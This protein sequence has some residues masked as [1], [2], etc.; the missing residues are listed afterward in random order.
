MAQ[1]HPN[2][3]DFGPILVHFGPLWPILSWDFGRMTRFK[4]LS[5]TS[6]FKAAVSKSI[7]ILFTPI[8]VVNSLRMINFKKF[9]I[10]Q[11]SQLKTQES[12]FSM[13]LLIG[14]FPF[15]TADWSKEWALNWKPQKGNYKCVYDIQT[16]KNHYVHILPE[17]IN[18]PSQ[19]F[20][21]TIVHTSSWVCYSLY[22]IGCITYRPSTGLGCP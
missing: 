1:F 9:I 10:K 11:I 8:V 3:T 18:F 14:P 13:W 5:P 15:E 17:M 12:W 2:R 20:P 4:S 6:L 7:T 19:G 22:Y 21:D 16:D